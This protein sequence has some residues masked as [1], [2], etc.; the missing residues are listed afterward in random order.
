VFVIVLVLLGSGAAA[1]IAT[2]AIIALIAAGAV[3]VLAT[4]GLTAFLIWRARR[5]DREQFLPSVPPKIAVAPVAHE[6]PG[7]ERP[8]LEAPAPREVHHHWH[9]HLAP[10]A[11]PEQA[12]DIIRRQGLEQ[13]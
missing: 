13:H 6:L 12:A 1:A 9:L 5:P 4:A 8:A 10:G 7:Q 3:V 11:D 2:A